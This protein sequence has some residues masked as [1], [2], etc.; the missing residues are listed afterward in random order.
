[1]TTDKSAMV[2]TDDPKMYRVLLAITFVAGFGWGA[3]FGWLFL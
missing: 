3:T 1:M 2:N